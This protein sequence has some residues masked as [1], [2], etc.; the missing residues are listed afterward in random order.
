LLSDQ[1]Y[2]VFRNLELLNAFAPT[3]VASDVG[4]DALY[5]VTDATPP[6]Q[7]SRLAIQVNTSTGGAGLAWQ[8]QGRVFQVERASSVSGPFEPLSPILPDLSFDDPGAITNRMQSY[9]RLR[10]W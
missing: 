6:A 10:Q 5:I 3:N 8:G 9:Y 7:A 4:L 1:G 2:I